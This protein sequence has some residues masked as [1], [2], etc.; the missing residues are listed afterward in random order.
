MFRNVL[1]VSREWIPYLRA[2]RSLS[3]RNQWDRSHLLVKLPI[4]FSF[5]YR[6]REDRANY[7][8]W[9]S[10]MPAIRPLSSSGDGRSDVFPG[11]GAFSG[12]FASCRTRL[13][14][15]CSPHTGASTPIECNRYADRRVGGEHAARRGAQR[16][17]S[18]SRGRGIVCWIILRSSHSTSLN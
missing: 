1:S 7:P 18:L 16:R 3:E 5:S 17:K 11:G 8:L 9:S 13:G 14:C 6:R 12:V 2:T 15:V 4:I 10:I